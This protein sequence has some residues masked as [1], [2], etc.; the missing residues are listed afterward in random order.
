M[1]AFQQALVHL[2]L[3]VLAVAA[4]VVLTVTGNFTATA[5]YI[6]LA[7]TGFG[8]VGVAGSSPTVS[9]PAV[10]VVPVKPPAGPSGG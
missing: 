5:A 7:V 6:V 1:T 9:G 10:P 4:V 3:V 8:S 2:A